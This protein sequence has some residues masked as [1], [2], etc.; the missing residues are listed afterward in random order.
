MSLF[1][2][3]ERSLA[4][5]LRAMTPQ[6]RN[7]YLVQLPPALRERVVANYPMSLLCFLVKERF[8]G[9]DPAPQYRL[10]KEQLNDQYTYACKFGLSDGIWN[11]VI[12]K[13]HRQHCDHT[14]ERDDRPQ[15]EGSRGDCGML[16]QQCQQ[17]CRMGPRIKLLQSI[18]NAGRQIKT[19]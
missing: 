7:A 3:L 14:F 9:F 8:F 2:R 17:Y 11:T 13:C 19:I 12:V 16:C 5:S 10:T 6:E 15:W 1:V 4:Q 18:K